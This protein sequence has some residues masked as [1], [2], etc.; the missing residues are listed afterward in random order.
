LPDAFSIEL[1]VEKTY[2]SFYSSDYGSADTKTVKI[3]KAPSN[4]TVTYTTTDLEGHGEDAFEYT[5]S[6]DK[7]TVYPIEPNKS[8]QPSSFAINLTMTF[9]N[10]TKTAKIT[11]Y[12]DGVYL[13]NDYSYGT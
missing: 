7:I 13:C 6:G 12:Q 9:E 8:T 4:A 10:T 2:V 1:S 3:T 11:I 5:I